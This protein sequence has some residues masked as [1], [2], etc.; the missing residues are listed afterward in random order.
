MLVK[1]LFLLW[2]GCLSFSSSLGYGFGLAVYGGAKGAATT[3]SA[4][5]T[6]F[7]ALYVTDKGIGYYL[8]AFG[9]GVHKEI[10]I[11]KSFRFTAGGYFSLS[12]PYSDAVGPALSASVNYDLFC[13]WIC[14]NAE[15]QQYLGHNWAPRTALIRSPIYSSFA[16]RLG[17]A[18]WN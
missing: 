5:L 9:A 3:D 7:K 15:V 4:S 2:L 1:N 10:E 6:G 11:T 12:V 18:L 14:V 17:V 16:F 13:L 8:D